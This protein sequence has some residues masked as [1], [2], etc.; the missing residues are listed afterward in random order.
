MSLALRLTLVALAAVAVL[1][2]AGFALLGGPGGGGDP[3][4]LIPGI[5][6][7]PGT[8]GAQ[9][10]D[11]VDPLAYEEDREDELSARAAQGHSHVLYAK[12][13]GGAQATARRVAGYREEI[14]AAAQEADVDADT[15]EA[16]VFLESA[17]RPSAAADPKL[18][19]AVG[20]TQILAETGENLLGMR[21]DPAAA[22]AIGRSIARARRRGDDELVQRLRDRRRRV[23]ERFDPAAALAATGRYLNFARDELGRDDLAVTS[24]HMGVGNLQNVLEAYGDDDASYARLYFDSS[25]LDN[26]EAWSLLAELG[27]DSSTYLWRVG[28]AREMMR[29]HREDPDELARRQ[30]RHEAKNSAEEVLH[31]PEDTARYTTP[32]EL[33]EAYADGSVV[34]LPAAEL[35]RLGVR[36]DEQM[37]ELAGRI[38]EER[39]LYRGLRPEALALLVYLGA[40]TREISGSTGALTVTSSVRDDEYQ[41]LLI[42]TNPEATQSYSLHTTGY[43]FDVLRRYRSDGQAQAFQFLLDRLQSHDMIAWVRE[44]AAIHITVSKRAEELLPLL[45]EAPP[46]AEATAQPSS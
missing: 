39:A 10:A 9:D 15:L 42:G 37:G 38:D 5:G 16:I 31:P 20:L 34:P 26:D 30:A 1:A 36:L 41:D 3:P 25:P 6:Q 4:R 27:D 44:P 32:S 45:R 22:R 21:V 17:G 11:A 8:E 28:A 24:Y 12:S 33:T 7:A 2:A 13:P 46:A 40:G 35:G 29:L 23:D 43:A 18:E 14:E 19:G